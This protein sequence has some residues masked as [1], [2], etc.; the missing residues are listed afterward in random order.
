MTSSYLGEEEDLVREGEQTNKQTK[1]N[2]TRAEE[3]CSPFSK[4]ANKRKNTQSHN[5]RSSLVRTTRSRSVL[6]LLILRLLTDCH[7]SLWMNRADGWELPPPRI[8]LCLPTRQLNNWER[9][10]W[11]A[12]LV[13][14]Q[15]GRFI[16]NSWSSVKDRA[17]IRDNKTS[18]WMDVR[19]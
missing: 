6:I 16:N 8:L 11:V 2:A 18:R 19:L 14:P 13:N 10:N 3:I 5:T 4:I 15:G 9:Q 12:L 7:E 17:L 1:L